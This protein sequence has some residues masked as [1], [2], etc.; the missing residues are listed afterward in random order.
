MS[1]ADM[2]KQPSEVAGMFDDVA[3]KYDRTNAVLS[4]GNAALWRMAT[5]RAIDPKPGERVLDIAAGTGTS[6]VAIAR[7]GADVVAL[8]FSRGM[9]EEGRRRHPDIEFIEGNAEALPFGDDEF[10]AVTISFGLRNVQHPKQALDEMYRV[11]KPGGRVIICEFSKPPVAIMRASYSVYLKWVLPKVAGVTGSNSPAYTYLAESIAEW[12]D[13]GTLSQWIRAAGFSRVAYRNLT[14]GVVAL[15]RGH[16][17]ADAKI[18][19]SV[20]NRRKLTRRTSP[21]TAPSAQAT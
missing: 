8:D 4:M 6:A 7:T 10:D 13:Q 14:V 16:K 18:R 1:R 19:A 11:L 3:P 2:N 12:P 15:H 20:A 9:V 17:P 5:V 21:P